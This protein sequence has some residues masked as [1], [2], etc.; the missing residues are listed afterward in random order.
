M[1]GNYGDPLRY[2]YIQR[3][4][5]ELRYQNVYRDRG[6]ANSR[7]TFKNSLVFVC[8]AHFVCTIDCEVLQEADLVYRVQYRMQNPAKAG[9]VHR[10]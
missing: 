5:I 3:E 7:N 6:S 1:H 4:P 9:P 2:F 8:R 10:A